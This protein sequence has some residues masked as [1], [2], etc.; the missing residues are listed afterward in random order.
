MRKP[1]TAIPPTGNFAN[2][3]VGEG[4]SPEPERPLGPVEQRVHDEPDQ[5]IEMVVGEQD[6][7]LARLHWGQFVR[8]GPQAG[9]GVEDQAFVAR[10]DEQQGGGVAAELVEAAADGRPTAPHTADEKPQVHF[11]VNPQTPSHAVGGWAHRS[12]H[13]R[14]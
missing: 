12:S 4:R 8:D 10:S 14:T 3:P 13:R 9:P 7:D 11:S 6:G 5:V 1:P 2:A